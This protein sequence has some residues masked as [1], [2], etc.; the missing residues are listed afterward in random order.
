MIPINILSERNKSHFNANKI[1]T[2]Y[3]RKK[4]KSFKT[5]KTKQAYSSSWYSVRYFMGFYRLFKQTYNKCWK[6]LDK[7]ALQTVLKHLFNFK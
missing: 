1:V 2:C 4:K 3:F 7:T 5:L 6:R